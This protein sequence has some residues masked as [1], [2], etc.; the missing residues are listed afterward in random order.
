LLLLISFHE[1]VLLFCFFLLSFHLKFA[2]VSLFCF[3]FTLL[4]T[5]VLLLSFSVPS[6]LLNDPPPPL[7]TSDADLSSHNSMWFR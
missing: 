4:S 6:E 1:V 7:S 2:F 5:D 3:R